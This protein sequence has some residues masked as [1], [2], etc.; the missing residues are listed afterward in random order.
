M[1]SLLGLSKR[2]LII[3]LFIWLTLT[4]FSYSWLLKH[5]QYYTFQLSNIEIVEGKARYITPDLILQGYVDPPP[6][7][8]I[9]RVIKAIQWPVRFIAGSYIIWFIWKYRKP[10]NRL[11]KKLELKP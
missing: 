8:T 3:I 5:P 9:Y 2:R 7:Y 6:A 10:L 11:I 4:I 1:K